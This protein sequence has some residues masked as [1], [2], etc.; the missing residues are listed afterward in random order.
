MKKIIFISFLVIILSFTA[1]LVFPNEVDNIN[2]LAKVSMIEC[3]LVWG[4][5]SNFPDSKSEFDIYTE[6]NSFTRSFRCSFYLPKSDLD[7]W[8]KRSPGLQDAEIQTIDSSKGKYI[9]KPGG[10]AS[11][12]EVVIDSKN[13]FVE[14]Y[15]SWS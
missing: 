3:T 12:A 8:I 6:G 4:R 1:Y 7:E 5:L 15:V 2:P 9:I 11:Y 13:C 14:I 10:G